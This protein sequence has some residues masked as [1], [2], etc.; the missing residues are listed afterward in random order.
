M[1]VP[2]SLYPYTKKDELEVFLAN[3]I[4]ISIEDFKKYFQLGKSSRTGDIVLKAGYFLLSNT[5]KGYGNST[6]TDKIRKR[7][8][9][10]ES[11][12]LNPNLIIKLQIEIEDAKVRN[13]E[14]DRIRNIFSEAE[15]L[16]TDITDKYE[17]GTDLSFDEGFSV[18]FT[19]SGTSVYDK[20]KYFGL[21]I[22]YSPKCLGGGG[23]YYV[24]ERKDGAE[25][26][27]FYDR[28][29]HLMNVTINNLGVIEEV[30]FYLRPHN[31]DGFRYQLVTRDTRTLD[32]LIKFTDASIFWQVELSDFAEM[33][34]KQINPKFWELGKEL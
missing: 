5:E 29:Y 26:R 25:G 3:E 33:I 20:E 13:A 4:G 23:Q 30:E 11:A 21:Y 10:G 14:Y 12:S 24:K 7:F 1:I 18:S 9:K 34:K 16:V 15:K 19:S 6:E 8:K 17:E 28:Y 2:D 22:Q 27:M 31:Q 32:K